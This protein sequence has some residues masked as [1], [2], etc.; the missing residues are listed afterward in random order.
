MAPSLSVFRFIVELTANRGTIPNV[1]RAAISDFSLAKEISMYNMLRAATINHTIVF[2][3]SWFP[4]ENR[5]I[6]I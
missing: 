2:A 6:Y 1:F 3:S 5:R 4:R